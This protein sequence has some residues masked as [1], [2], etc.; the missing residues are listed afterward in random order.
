MQLLIPTLNPV[1]WT[2]LQ[3]E[4]SWNNYMFCGSNNESDSEIQAY[5]KTNYMFYIMKCFED[6]VSC[7]I[8]SAEIN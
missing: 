6:F 8:S 2:I 5:K 1:A 4:I 7:I 3:T